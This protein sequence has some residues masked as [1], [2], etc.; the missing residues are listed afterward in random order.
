MYS[1]AYIFIFFFRNWISYLI[2]YKPVSKEEY[3]AFNL[4]Q[5]TFRI[6][7][8]ERESFLLV[9]KKYCNFIRELFSINEKK[10]TVAFIR[11][12][13]D[14][15]FVYD[16]L[17]SSYNQRKNYVNYFSNDCVSGG[18]FK[19]DLYYCSSIFIAMILFI[20]STIWM[21]FLFL[22]SLFKND[23]APFAMIFK[24]VLETFNLFIL[25]EELNIK[26]LYCFSIYEKD[27]NVCTLLLQKRGI[28]VVKIPSE[29]PISVWNKII[30]A[31][32]LCLCSGYQFDELKEFKKS[33]FVSE[34]DFYGPEKVLDNIFKYQ[35]PIEIKKQTIGFYSTGSWIRKLEN[36][37]EQGLDME[38][39]ENLVKLAIRNFCIKNSN[40]SLIVFLHPREKWY[41]Y[42]QLTAEKYSKEFEGISYTFLEGD[43]KSSEAFELADLG[44]AFQ[45]T[46]VYERLYYGF[47]T[48]LMPIGYEN[49]PLPNSGMQNICVAT[50]KELFGKIE[51]SISLSNTEFF[52]NNSIRHFAKFLYN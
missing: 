3:A 6:P 26:T 50:E 2:C 19:N 25:I 39:M 4:F 7:Q 31:D 37:I 24:E 46:I 51:S 40:Y 45:S 13:D 20:L 33:I 41:K 35:K 9:P 36:H 18:V 17:E 30:I 12:N 10:Q 21:P 5:S 28:R 29:V 48:I 43:I 27:S 11:E 49:F 42:K 52:E 1:A 32:K 22:S 16:L 44:I 15:V 47:K 14:G 23:K 8:S 34:I 38:E